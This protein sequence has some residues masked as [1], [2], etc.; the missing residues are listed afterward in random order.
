MDN[1]TKIYKVPER[2]LGTLEERIEK[3]NKRARKL[4][5]PEVVVTVRLQGLL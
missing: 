1:E 5:M 3:L 4:H 2:N